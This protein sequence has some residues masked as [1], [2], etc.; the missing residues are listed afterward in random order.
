MPSQINVARVVLYVGLDEIGNWDGSPGAVTYRAPQ[1][2]PN[3]IDAG[4]I[5]QIAVLMVNKCHK[6]S[7]QALT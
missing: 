3:K 2:S 5:C 4:R 7:W 1:G 6:E